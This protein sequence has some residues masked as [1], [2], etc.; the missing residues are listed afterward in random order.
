MKTAAGCRVRGSVRPGRTIR[1]RICKPGRSA[2]IQTLAASSVVIRDGGMGW[3][4]STYEPFVPLTRSCSEPWP[5]CA[6][7]RARPCTSMRYSRS[8]PAGRQEV[9]GPSNPSCQGASDGAARAP[10]AIAST[11]ARLASHCSGEKRRIGLA[12]LRADAGFVPRIATV[13]Q[14]NRSVLPTRVVR[15]HSPPI[16]CKSRCRFVLR[17]RS[18]SPLDPRHDDCSNRGT[19]PITREPP[20]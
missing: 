4:K 9:F 6:P 8:A 18:G 20:P 17:W 19:I 2:L 15:A 10:P 12:S 1:A 16:V 14:C 5:V 13:L 7:P 11:P 3:L